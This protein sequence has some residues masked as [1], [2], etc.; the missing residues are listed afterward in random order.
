MIAEFLVTVAQ[1]PYALAL[2]SAILAVG[3]LLTRLALAK[4]PVAR[5]VVQLGSFLGFTMILLA[6]GLTPAEPTSKQEPV[7]AY[8]A[9][10]AFKVIWW[11]AA[12]W[13][14]AGFI[15]AALALKRQPRE[16]RFVQDIVVAIIYVA[17]A[18]GIVADVFDVSITGM[19]AASGVIAIVLG[20]ALT[21]IT[22]QVFLGLK[23]NIHLHPLAL[24]YPCLMIFYTLALWLL[25][26]KN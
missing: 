10:S 13:L 9:I 5:F 14:V 15:R 6:A 25:L 19:L 26:F 24:V 12:A 1:L 8:F 21:L 17:A 7:A 16:T 18:L 11:L 23:L 22:R 20:L 3:F 4:H 2:A